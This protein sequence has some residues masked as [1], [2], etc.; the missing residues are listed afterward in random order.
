MELLM[1]KA[2]ALIV[3]VI[4]AASCIPWLRH[5]YFFSVLV[6]LVAV[7]LASLLIYGGWVKVRSM[8]RLRARSISQITHWSPRWRKFLIAGTV[9]AAAML[10]V[11]HFI[12]TSS[13]A[14]ILTI[15]A[16]RKNAEFSTILG[17]PV[18]EAWFSEGTLSFGNPQKAELVIPVRGRIRKGELQAIAIKQDGQWKLE[19]LTLE[20]IAAVQARFPATEMTDYLGCT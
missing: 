20:V 9:I 5:Q 2:T 16:A 3:V 13:G 17:T 14:Y 12:A 6:A 10:T 8:W 7:T 4:V 18:K 15:Q 1:R 19:K 11:P